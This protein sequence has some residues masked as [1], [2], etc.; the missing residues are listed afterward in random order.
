MSPKKHEEVLI[1]WNGHGCLIIDGRATPRWPGDEDVV[2]YH[3]VEGSVRSGKVSV[4]GRPD[5]ILVM[6]TAEETN[7]E[8]SESEPAQ[9]RTPASDYS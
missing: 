8:R 7:D 2:E 4:I 1:R 6:G 9:K 5:D 3:L